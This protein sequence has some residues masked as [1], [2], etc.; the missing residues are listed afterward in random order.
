MGSFLFQ[1]VLQEGKDSRFDK[2]KTSPPRFWV[3]FMVQATWV[4][5]C[6]MPVMAVNAIP[7]AAFGAGL[8]LTD[9]LGL[10]L[11]LGGITFESIADRQKSAWM[12]EKRTKQHDEEFLTRGLWNKR[13]PP[14]FFAPL[15]LQCKANDLKPT[16]QLLR[17]IHPVDR[18][19]YDICGRAALA[20]CSRS[21]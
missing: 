14:P 7:A 15:R 12:H 20:T 13:Y 10:S 11:Y 5:L 18:H 4:S 17:R 8:K 2:I 19:R 21:A 9:L 6:L 16:P 3:A 1:R